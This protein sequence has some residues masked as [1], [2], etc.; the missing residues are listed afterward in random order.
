MNIFIFRAISGGFKPEVKGFT[1]VFMYVFHQY[2]S[3]V[4]FYYIIYKQNINSS[5]FLSF[6][7]VTFASNSPYIDIGKML[8][9]Y[10]VLSLPRD[11]SVGGYR[12][13]GVA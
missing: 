8:I 3:R 12:G 11:S 9:K 4:T 5:A 13:R 1:Q 6:F 10:S 7:L 2:R